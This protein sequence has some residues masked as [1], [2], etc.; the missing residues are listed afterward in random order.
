MKEPTS[1]D[2]H[3]EAQNDRIES[4]D[5]SLCPNPS[6]FSLTGQ[7]TVQGKLTIHQAGTP[8]FVC[9]EYDPFRAT[10]AGAKICEAT[11]IRPSHR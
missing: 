10:A 9:A 2:G 3:P 8:V 7:L 1:T 6:Q 11:R 4:E 5:D